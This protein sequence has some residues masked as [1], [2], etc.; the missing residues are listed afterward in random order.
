M[1]RHQLNKIVNCLG[2]L[3]TKVPAD[4]GQFAHHGK[5]TL[6]HVDGVAHALK[7]DLFGA[8]GHLA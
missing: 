8:H 7:D 1:I 4:G 2:V 3:I 5:E 6:K